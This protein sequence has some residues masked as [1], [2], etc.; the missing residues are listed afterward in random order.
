[1]ISHGKS[2]GGGAISKCRFLASR[3]YNVAE[4]L[5]FHPDGGDDHIVLREFRGDRQRSLQFC[6]NQLQTVFEIGDHDG[7]CVVHR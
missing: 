5:V 6:E 4:H 3:H 2:S 1:M 7:T